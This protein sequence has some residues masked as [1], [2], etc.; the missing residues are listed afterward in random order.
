VR[1]A[2]QD[3]VSAQVVVSAA[4]WARVSAQAVVSA[5]VWARVSGV[6]LV[7]TSEQTEAAVQTFVPLYAPW[8][9]PP[10]KQQ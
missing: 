2:G 6:D 10:N 8:P 7:A 4:V 1:D 5:A 3:S 9:S